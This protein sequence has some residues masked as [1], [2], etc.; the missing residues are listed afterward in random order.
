MF[1][2]GNFIQLANREDEKLMG[3]LLLPWL[4]A[5]KGGVGGPL[6]IYTAQ[7]F[8]IFGYLDK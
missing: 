4:Y 1:V 3:S 2:P 7:S 6:F 8:L 5:R